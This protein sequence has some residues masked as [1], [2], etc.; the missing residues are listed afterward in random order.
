M[1]LEEYKK[2]GS[3]QKRVETQELVA[4]MILENCQKNGFTKNEAK[5]FVNGVLQQIDGGTKEDKLANA[6]M[7]N[8]ADIVKEPMKKMEFRGLS[9]GFKLFDEYAMGFKPGEIVVMG[10]YPHKGK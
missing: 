4:K 7:E 6:E 1:T 5:S 2:V 9:S 10:G 8:L 3:T